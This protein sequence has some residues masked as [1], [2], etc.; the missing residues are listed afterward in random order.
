MGSRWRLVGGEASGHVPSPVVIQK[1]TDVDKESTIVY[2]PGVMVSVERL[3]WDAWSVEHIARHGVT[4]DDVETL[5]RR[6]PVVF[7]QSYKDRLVILGQDSTDRVLAVV[8]GPVP[9]EPPGVYY[10]F[11]AR[12]AHRSE[13]RHYHR[14]KGGGCDD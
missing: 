6:A 5:C 8:L 10:V 14:L 7:K 1:A 9:N 11:T 13:R 3:D 2:N 12:P 4:Q